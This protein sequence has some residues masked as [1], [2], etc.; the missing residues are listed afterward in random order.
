MW[1]NQEKF[2][3]GYI[4]RKFFIIKIK[5]KKW[6]KIKNMIMINFTPSKK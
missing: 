4:K 2:Y 1:Y 3:R 5:N 6:Q